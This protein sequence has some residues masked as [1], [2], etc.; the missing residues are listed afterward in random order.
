MARAGRTCVS[1]ASPCSESTLPLTP[2]STSVAASLMPT[3][4]LATR[5]TT[6]EPS[7]FTMPTA[8]PF[9]APSMG[10]VTTPDTPSKR[11]RAKLRVPAP[12]P[13][14]TLDCCRSVSSRRVWCFMRSALSMV[15]LLTWFESMSVSRLAEFATPPTE[16]RSRLVVPF[17]MPLTRWAGLACSTDAR[18]PCMGSATK[19]LAPS[20]RDRMSP[21]G[22]PSR[23]S[24]PIISRKCRRISRS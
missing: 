14:M 8:P 7:P 2:R 5:P 4:G 22:L 11:L 9:L 18:R 15:R 16:F 19:S 13:L 3:T 17:L 10:F 6:P 1:G 20:R 21:T 12:R 23:C 24:A